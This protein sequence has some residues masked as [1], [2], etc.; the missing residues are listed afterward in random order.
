MLEARAGHCPSRRAAQI[1]IH[2]LDLVPAQLTQAFLHCVLQLL[3]LQVVADLMGRGLANVEDRLACQM[4]C[5]D[6]VTHRTP[7][8]PR[9]RRARSRGARATDAPTTA[10]SAAGSLAAGSPRRGSGV[11]GETG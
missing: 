3:A 8:W 9:W 10:G 7:P 1:L 4:L 6:L 5:S 11:P 2:D